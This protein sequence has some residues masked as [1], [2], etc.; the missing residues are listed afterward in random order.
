MIDPQQAKIQFEKNASNYNLA[1]DLLGKEFTIKNE[2]Y[3]FVGFS[4]RIR[5]NPVIMKNLKT[6]ELHKFPMNIIQTIY[7]VEA[8]SNEVLKT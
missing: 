6:Q 4:R 1:L 8:F 7:K 3:Q 2:L 5:K